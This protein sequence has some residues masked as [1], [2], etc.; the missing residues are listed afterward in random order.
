[1]YCETYSEFCKILFLFHIE[2][3]DAVILA[4][5]FQSFDFDLHGG[6]ADGIRHCG[7]AGV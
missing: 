1:M 2:F 6:T 5:I 7:M 4:W 3:V